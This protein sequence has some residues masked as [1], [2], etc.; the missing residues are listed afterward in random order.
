MSDTP[1]HTDT[2]QHEQTPSITVDLSDFSFHVI[3][4]RTIGPNIG[5]KHRES[6][7][8]RLLSWGA[9]PASPLRAFDYNMI[10]PPPRPTA[11][12]SLNS[13]RR[14]HVTAHAARSASPRSIVVLVA[15]HPPR[16]SQLPLRYP[17]RRGR[18]RR[19]PPEC[20]CAV[21][22]AFMP[23]DLDCTPH[24]PCDRRARCRRQPCSMQLPQ[25]S[26]H[27]DLSWLARRVRRFARPPLLK[28]RP[29]RLLD[30]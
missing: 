8:S 18:A 1:T 21:V 4:D 12:L 17:P 13:H 30:R 3:I 5:P 16:L 20:T 27:S 14:A 25:L 22:A 19:A 15:Q 7:S 11:T 23:R 10:I 29:S 26:V 9:H 28:A 6:R 24:V 2:R